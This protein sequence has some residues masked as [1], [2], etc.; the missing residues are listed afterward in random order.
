V[1]HVQTSCHLRVRPR[2]VR[3]VPGHLPVAIGFI[4]NFAVPTAFD[5]RPLEERD[6][7]TK[8]GALYRNYRERTPMLTTLWRMRPKTGIAELDFHHPR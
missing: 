3:A 6:L 4:G 7:V 1:N 8:Y 2:G 5:P